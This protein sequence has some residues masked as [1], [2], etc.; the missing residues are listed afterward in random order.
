MS[1]HNTMPAM[2]YVLTTL[3]AGLRVA[4]MEM[5]QMT[6]VALGMWAG[7]GGRHEHASHSGI[8]HFIEH[9]NFKGTRRRTARAIAREIECVGGAS[10]GFTSEETTCFYVKVPSAH[11]ACALD[12]LNDSYHHSIFP[13]HE[14]RRERAVI[15][16]EARM[17]QDMPQQ[18]V[19]DDFN[20]LIWG[21]H[22]L[23][24]PLI[25]TAAT[26][27]AFS[28]E[29]LLAYRNQ[30]YTTG[31]TVISVAGNVR[32]EQVLQLLNA[33]LGAWRT[34][35]APAACQ[36]HHARQARPRV[37][38]RVKPIEQAHVVLGF[39][40]AGRRSPQRYALR[41]LCTILGETMSSRLNQE[42]REKRGLAYS[43]GASLTRF[44]E[45]GM[46]QISVS[47]EVRNVTRVV[48]LALD[49][50]AAL[51]RDGVRP[52]ELQLAQ[53][54]VRGT[55]VLSLERT[56]DCMMW[57]GE[58]LITR[59]V[60]ENTAEMLARYDAVTCAD[61]QAAARDLFVDHKLSAA[62]VS[63]RLDEARVTAA[64]RVTL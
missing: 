63:P 19:Y 30:H 35:G 46:L 45:T 39:R 40:S 34:D 62:F 14:L 53:E 3:P 41:L 9:M 31:N 27:A 33:R 1:S 17:Y 38:L 44:H 55:I 25:G 58:S 16:E 59:G 5:P 2:H 6:S 26:I 22:P 37:H 23:G 56:T 52:R 20:V 21:D 11:V 10:N 8:S 47:A 60:I 29:Q 32:H 24:R 61:I 18:L 54:Y 36:P 28:R 50:C 57:L 48:R 51:A 64:V 42:I 4:T 43:V 49:I 7:V 12:V 13:A 15:H